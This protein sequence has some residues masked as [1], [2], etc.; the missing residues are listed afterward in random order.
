MGTTNNEEFLPPDDEQRRYWPVKVGFIDLA[1]L[2]TDRSQLFAEAV[3]RYSAGENWWL[4]GNDIALAEIEAQAVSRASP[5]VEPILNW[6][7][8]LSQRPD[9]VSTSQIAGDA[10][11][12]LTAQVTGG[13]SQEIGKA[14][15]SLGFLRTKK[16]LGGHP[17]NVY[18]TPPG[19]MDATKTTT[20]AILSSVKK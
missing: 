17:V 8:K 19:L 2:T 11:N 12:M 6:W 13:V 3:T 15:R 16:R 4:E 14:L 1:S 20:T 18:R 5:Y 10:L 9:T 7:L